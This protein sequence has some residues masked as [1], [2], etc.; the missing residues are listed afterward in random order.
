MLVLACA[1][2]ITRVAMLWIRLQTDR[3]TAAYKEVEE[4]SEMYLRNYLST[5]LSNS[6]S[7][8]L[9]SI[10]TVHT[11]KHLIF[12]HLHLHSPFSLPHLCMYCEWIQQVHGQRCDRSWCHTVS[13]RQV[14]PHSSISIDGFYQDAH[15][16]SEALRVC[17]VGVTQQGDLIVRHAQSLVT[18]RLLEKPNRKQGWRPGH[19]VTQ[20]VYMSFG[21][22]LILS[23]DFISVFTGYI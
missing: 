23:L 6:L 16:Q 2:F 15:R 9:K 12:P 7:I 17:A 11:M 21:R 5:F 20:Q 19:R 13:A 3:Q 22:S 10:Y 4:D 8:L 1:S 18:Q 14:D